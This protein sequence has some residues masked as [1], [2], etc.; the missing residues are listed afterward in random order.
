MS[1][2]SLADY[3]ATTKPGGV[4]WRKR[5]A[6]DALKLVELV[7]ARNPSPSPAALSQALVQVG[8]PISR[9]IVGDH[10]LGGCSCRR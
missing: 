4:C 1:L 3:V 10:Y 6:G 7:E 9:R 5:L 8:F 2:E